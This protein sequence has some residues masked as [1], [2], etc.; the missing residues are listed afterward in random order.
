MRLDNNP[1]GDATV[2]SESVDCG[3]AR[4]KVSLTYRSTKRSTS[5]S[6]STSEDHGD[7]DDDRGSGGIS[8]GSL[9]SLGSGEPEAS[10]SINRNRLP[11][12]GTTEIYDR[13]ALLYELARPEHFGTVE[14]IELLQSGY[15]NAKLS[16]ISD[17]K[18]AGG[19]GTPE[20]RRKLMVEKLRE[21][22]QAVPDSLL[23]IWT[24]T[25]RS[26]DFER[27]FDRKPDWLD[28]DKYRRGQKFAQDN[29][30]GILYSQMMTCFPV[31]SFEDGLKTLVST[32]KSDTPY[33][34]FVR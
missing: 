8:E 3:D 16:S 27:P 34:A 32:G 30:F 11:V 25:V 15:A 23:H 12:P 33:D 19:D 7:S 5:S 4:E 1:V 18:D 24:G 29:T 9:D 17:D 28:M 13:E 31:F 14:K 20:E 22:L 21:I 26:G 2:E 10:H 6:A